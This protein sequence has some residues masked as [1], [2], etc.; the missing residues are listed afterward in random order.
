MR[1][2]ERKEYKERGK[3]KS[4]KEQGYPVPPRGSVWEKLMS[5]SI[6]YRKTPKTSS[7]Q[8]K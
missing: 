2:L 3:E 7:D 1:N 5:M 4:K 8:Y 6:I